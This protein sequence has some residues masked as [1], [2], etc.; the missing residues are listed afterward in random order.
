MN[1]DEEIRQV[2]NEDDTWFKCVNYKQTRETMFNIENTETE[3]QN[4]KAM[5]RQIYKVHSNSTNRD[6]G[7]DILKYQEEN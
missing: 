7:R 6:E 1:N 4:V 5:R 2:R 3:Y